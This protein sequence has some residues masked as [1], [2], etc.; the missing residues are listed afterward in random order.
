[1]KAYFVYILECSDSSYYTG[2]TNNLTRRLDEHQSG[3]DPYCYTYP[4]RPIEMVFVQEFQEIK[5]AI[6]FEKQL[7]GWS[8]KKKEAVINGDWN[9]L[10]SLAECRNATSHTNFSND[11][12][13]SLSG[14]KEGF[15]SAQPDS[16]SA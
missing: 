2:V 12:N 15:D 11:G 6:S 9:K 10:K 3:L 1:M 5:A 13:S 8:R 7:K 14:K 4:R 16:E